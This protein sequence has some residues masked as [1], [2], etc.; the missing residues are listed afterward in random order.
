VYAIITAYVRA[1]STS[2]STL[3]SEQDI[4][5]TYHFTKEVVL[6]SASAQFAV[7]LEYHPD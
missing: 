6:Y 2:F 5:A 4:K 7:R 3:Y 1:S